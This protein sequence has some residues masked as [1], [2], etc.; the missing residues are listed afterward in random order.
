[1]SVR[2]VDILDE[3]GILACLTDDRTDLDA[4]VLAMVQAEAERDDDLYWWEGDRP[5]RL[6]TTWRRDEL[7]VSKFRKQPCICGYHHDWDLLP[8]DEETPAR[9][10]FWGILG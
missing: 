9:G 5:T 4:A 1:M 2:R 6:S 10:S 7:L 3:E 8:V